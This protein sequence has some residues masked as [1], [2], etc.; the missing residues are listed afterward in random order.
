MRGRLIGVLKDKK[1]NSLVPQWSALSLP[2]TGPGSVPGW[3]AKISE[4]T[5]FMPPKRMQR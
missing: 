4:A 1:G 2:T 5:W 3:G